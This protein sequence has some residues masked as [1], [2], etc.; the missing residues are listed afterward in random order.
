MKILKAL[1]INLLAKFL[2]VDGG[3]EMNGIKIL[4][5]F[6]F[7]TDEEPKSIYPFSPVYRVTGENN[8][9]II[10]KTQRTMER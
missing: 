9:F 1:L 3:I 2:E 7:K 4:D 10:K 5:T 8:D 6:G